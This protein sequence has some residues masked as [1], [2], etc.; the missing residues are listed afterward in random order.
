MTGTQA[1]DRAAMLVARVVRADEPVGFSALADETGLPRSTTSRLLTALERNLLLARDSDGTFTAGPLFSEYAAGHDPGRELGRLA[2][3]VL[4]EI[5]EL[6]GETVH[7]GVPNGTQVVQ[8]AQVDSRYVLGAR[9]WSQIDVP[10]HCSAQGKV[11]L[12]HGALRMPTEPLETPTDRSHSS[13]TALQAELERICR[14]GYAVTVDELEEGLSA[15][16]APVR[17][18]RLLAALGVSGPTARIGPD[19][20]RIGRTLVEQADS[21]SS[22][23]RRRRTNEEGAA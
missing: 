11:L 21:L 4:Q 6:T 23:L 16:A 12:A 1:V 13:L 19:A 14:A 18:G 17:A 3:P 5:A 15:V 20:D 22:R 9:D 10:S 2:E 7:L 8:V